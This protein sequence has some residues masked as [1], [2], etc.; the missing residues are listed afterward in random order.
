MQCN[1]KRTNLNSSE[2]KHDYSALILQ[3]RGCWNVQIPS[4]SVASL[5]R[6]TDPFH[7]TAFSSLGD[8]DFVQGVSR[9]AGNNK[10]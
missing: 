1:L 5:P 4:P 8:G 10:M 9:F 2:K 7:P 3:K 6:T